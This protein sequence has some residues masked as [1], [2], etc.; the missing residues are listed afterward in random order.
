MNENDEPTDHVETDK[1][2][3]PN[4]VAIITAVL[5]LIVFSVTHFTFGFPDMLIHVLILPIIIGLVVRWSLKLNSTNN[6]R[7]DWPQYLIQLLSRQHSTPNVAIRQ[8]R[9]LSQKR[10]GSLRGQLGKSSLS[11]NDPLAAISNAGRWQKPGGKRHLNCDPRS[12]A[13]TWPSPP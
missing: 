13:L 10:I 11:A 4:Q 9:W 7:R 5:S 2:V 6:Y 1:P 12:W 3:R 8:A